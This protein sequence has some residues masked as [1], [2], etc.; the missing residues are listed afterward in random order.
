MF[1]LRMLDIVVTAINEFDIAMKFSP[2]NS[3]YT[4]ILSMKQLICYCCSS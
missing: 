3:G 4:Y 1:L 2:K